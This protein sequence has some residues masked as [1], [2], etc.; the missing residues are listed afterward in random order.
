MNTVEQRLHH[1]LRQEFRPRFGRSTQSF[2]LDQEW[3]KIHKLGTRLWLDTG[4]LTEAARLWTAPFEALTTNNTL[5]N[6][7]VQKGMYDAFVVDVT[8]MILESGPLPTQQLVL[9]VAFALNA[10]HALRL[11]ERFDAFVS[12][13][14]HTDLANDISRTIEYGK[15]LFS[16]CPERFIVKVPLTAAGH[17]GAMGLVQIGVPINFTLGFSAR[18]SY[19]AALLTRPKFVNVFVGRLNAYVHD[20]KLGTGENVGEKAALAAQRALLELRRQ[21]QT[22][23]HLIGASVRSGKQIASLAGLDVLTMPPM[24]AAEYR[25]RPL[26]AV[27]SC[28]NEDPA[29]PLAPGVSAA[30]FGGEALWTVS[31]EFKRAVETL[32]RGEMDMFTADMLQEYFAVAGFPD[33][34]PQWSAE[35]VLTVTKDGKIPVHE[36]WQ[37]RL[38][39]GEIG[40]DALMN[41]SAL[42]SFV[43]DQRA[44]DDRIRG[45]LRHKRFI[46]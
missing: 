11:V 16:V 31:T 9:E 6:K 13:E 42:Q 20:N 32:L 30:Q 8:R 35:D 1:F 22:K 15:R 10:H 12:V 40:L 28:L 37:A 41:L 38:A 27:H 43:I 26:P 24:A 23:T 29:I 39:A 25:S 19:L 33:L 34:F 7:E 4:D 3:E 18:Q 5:L 17:L 46:S 21:S 45:I 44:L 36:K 14:L 2:H